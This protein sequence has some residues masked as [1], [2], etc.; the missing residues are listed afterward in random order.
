MPTPAF[1]PR[2][3]SA[4]VARAAPVRRPVDAADLMRYFS[5]EFDH[6][7]RDLGVRER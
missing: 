2:P 6:M 5:H 3:Q 1:A 4:P 7:V